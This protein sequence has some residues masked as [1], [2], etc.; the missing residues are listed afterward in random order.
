MLEHHRRELPGSTKPQIMDGR[1]RALR[2]RLKQY[3]PDVLHAGTG[4]RCSSCRP[5]CSRAR[6]RIDGPS[7]WRCATAS[8]GRI[9][10]YALGSALED[11]DEE[12]CRIGSAPLASTTRSTCRRWPTLPS[13]KNQVDDREPAARADPR[14]G[15]SRPV[16]TSSLDTHRGARSPRPGPT[17]CASAQVIQTDRQLPAQRHPLRLSAR[18]AR[19]RNARPERASTIGVATAGRSPP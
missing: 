1:G 18:A 7:A 16:T 8:R 5:R 11:H 17:G 9:V 19:T 12:G 15:V 3:P 13:V 14:S 2:R 6:S 4:G 10:A